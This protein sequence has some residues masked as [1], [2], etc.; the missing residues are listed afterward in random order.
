MQFTSLQVN[1]MKFNRIDLFFSFFLLQILETLF[2]HDIAMIYADLFVMCF[3]NFVM[4]LK[5]EHFIHEF[6]T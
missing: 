3:V 1:L 5:I 6:M 4:L 2:V